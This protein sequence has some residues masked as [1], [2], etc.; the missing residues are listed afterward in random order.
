MTKGSI[1]RHLV[2][3]A[4][5]M[6]IGNAIQTSYSIINAIWVGL[7]LGKTELAAITVSFSVIF[8]MMSIAIGLTMG[9]GILISQYA[10]AKNWAQ[11]KRIVQTS[12]ILVG[13][14]SV[15]LLV[16]SQ[17]STPWILS[18][19]GTA[20]DVYPLAVSYMRIFLYTTPFTFGIFLA[21]SMLRGVGDSK[22]PLYFQAGAVLLTA[23]FDPILMFGWLGFPKLG[24]NGT[25]ISTLVMQALALTVT[26]IYLDKK[27]HIVAPDW[28]KLRIDWP[29][30]WII[31]KIALPA[32]VQQSLMSIGLMFVVGIINSYGENATAAFGAA[33]R[34]D[35]VAVLPMMTIG[36][37]VSTLVGQNIGANRVGRVKEIFL[38][39]LLLSGGITFLVSLAAVTM[40]H[41]LIRFFVTDPAVLGIGVSYLKIVGG[42]YVF[43]SVLFVGNGV[44][45]GAGYTFVTT[46]ISLVS[47]W[48]TRVPLAI[49]LSHR[50]HRIEGIWYAIVISIAVSMLISLGCYFS[51]LWKR[52]VMKHITHFDPAE[53]E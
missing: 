34:I 26:L 35:Q 14:V 52:P 18:K 45:N 30:F 8:I 13:I 10:G 28:K 53:A 25:A 2:A 37:A 50:L 47:L 12:V 49:Y 20:K 11:L 4:M 48:V 41:I 17:L 31:N 51:G 15:L 9:I 32:V 5:P 44:L 39:G 40:P 46:V 27:D 23:I 21:I 43:S 24:L 3:F 29:S 1:P 16:G 38:W 36:A 22:T 33:M 6:L 42:C 19:L 7:K